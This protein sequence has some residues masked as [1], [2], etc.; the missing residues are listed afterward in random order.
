M[1]KG[2]KGASNGE[3]TCEQSRLESRLE[4]FVKVSFE[5]SIWSSL[6]CDPVAAASTAY[7]R[8]YVVCSCCMY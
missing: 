5:I 7:M 1:F 8:S 3:F 4:V 2:A 6:G